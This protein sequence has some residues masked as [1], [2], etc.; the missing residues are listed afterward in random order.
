MKIFI[1]KNSIVD[2]FGFNGSTDSVDHENVTRY[3]HTVGHFEPK[4]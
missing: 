3:G 1:F 2:K 4:F